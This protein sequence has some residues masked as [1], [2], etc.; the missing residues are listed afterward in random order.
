LPHILLTFVS[1]ALLLAVVAFLKERRIRLA[2]QNL[3]RRLLSRWRTPADEDDHSP[4]DRS[5]RSDADR[6]R[7]PD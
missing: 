4:C 7:L 5:D 3:L 2:L 1:L 6:E